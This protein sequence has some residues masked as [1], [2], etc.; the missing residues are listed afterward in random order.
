MCR[1]AWCHILCVPI[2]KRKGKSVNK[3]VQ[4][5]VYAKICQSV[6]RFLLLSFC[7]EKNSPEDNENKNDFIKEIFN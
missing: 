3:V 4:L 5:Y 7:L 2:Y 6:C 1:I